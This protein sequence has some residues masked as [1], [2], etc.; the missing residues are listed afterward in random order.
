MCLIEVTD[1][2]L[3]LAIKRCFCNISGVQIPIYRIKKNLAT[4]VSYRE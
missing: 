4:I 2:L 3:F 1:A